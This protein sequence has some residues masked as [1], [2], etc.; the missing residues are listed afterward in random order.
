[1]HN[2]TSITARKI[3]RSKIIKAAE[4]DYKH[5]FRYINMFLA[6]ID[7][8]FIM[9]KVQHHKDTTFKSVN[10]PR[11]KDRIGCGTNDYEKKRK[12]YKNMRER[13]YG[14]LDEYI[15]NLDTPVIRRYY[16]SI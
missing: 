12:D 16:N 14:L 3:F 8:V 6:I 13:K 4:L 5:K 7:G 2:D 1:M 10:K 9:P 15:E 11:N